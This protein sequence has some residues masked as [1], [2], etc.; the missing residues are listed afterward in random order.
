MRRFF[1]RFLGKTL[2]IDTAADTLTG[3]KGGARLVHRLGK[4]LS[5]SLRAYGRLVF[6]FFLG[7]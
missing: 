3:S 4:P 6:P 5:L 7:I 2:K 1:F